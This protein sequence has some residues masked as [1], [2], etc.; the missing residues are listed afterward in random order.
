MLPGA[1]DPDGRDA[2]VRQSVA[3]LLANVHDGA[4]AASLIAAVVARH[5][6]ELGPWA[7]DQVRRRHPWVRPGTI[8]HFAPAPVKPRSDTSD[9]DTAVFAGLTVKRAP[10]GPTEAQAACFRADPELARLAVVLHLAAP[11][12][13]WVI[14]RELVRQSDGS[15]KLAAEELCAAVRRH[16]RVSA[17][18]LQRLL[19]TGD[20]LFWNRQGDTLYLRG[21]GYVS[22]QLVA[23]ADAVGLGRLDTNR[24]GARDMY[25]NVGGDLERFEAAI[26]A[27]WLAHRSNPT[28][29][30]SQLTQL[31]NRDKRTLIRWEK[32]H[33]AAVLRK[34]ANYAQCPDAATFWDLIPREYATSYT[35][36]TRFKGRVRRVKRIRWQLPNTYQIRGTRQ[37]PKRGQ[38]GKVR[39]AVNVSLDKPASNGEAGM[40]RLYVDQAATIRR[41]ARKH[42]E[43]EPLYLWRGED[44][45]GAGIFEPNATGFPQTHAWER[46]E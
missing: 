42:G 25:L 37:H 32:T 7:E 41:L 29:A 8:A 36:F 9:G 14:G 6:P 13:L 39:R 43:A 38:A 27:A 10:E 16:V 21:A 12:R 26:Y 4:Q 22:R 18:H 11:F 23:R 28:I 35:A 33:L 1:Q 5:A 2:Q 19:Q 30:R 44:R 24:P 34:R 3:E 17:R 31:F 20:G 46:R 45:S 15:G 40:H